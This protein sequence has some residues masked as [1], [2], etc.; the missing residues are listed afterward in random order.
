[1]ALLTRKRLILVKKETTYGTDSSPLGTDALLVRNLDITPIEAD[2][3][4]RDLIRP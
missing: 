2:L 1:M 4:S 3:V